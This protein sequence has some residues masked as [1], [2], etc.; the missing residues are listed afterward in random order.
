M[1]GVKVESRINLSKII[2]N[3]EIMLYWVKL[4]NKGEGGKKGRTRIK[5]I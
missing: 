2:K 1:T 4:L 5:V 3:N